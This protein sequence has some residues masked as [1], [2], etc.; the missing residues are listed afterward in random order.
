MADQKPAT[1]IDEYIGTFPADDREILEQIRQT[2]RKAAPG[3]TET[4]SYGMPTFDLNG[5]H[6]VFFAGWK[7]HISVYPVPAGDQALQERMAQ[8]KR[9]RGTIQFPLAKPT[10]YDLIGDMVTFLQR[11]KPAKAPPPNATGNASRG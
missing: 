4:I 6:L 9:A 7:R 2:I 5:E 8:Y 11:E 1:T 10:P 3:A